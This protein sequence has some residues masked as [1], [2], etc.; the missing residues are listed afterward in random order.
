MLTTFRSI[1]F[2]AVSCF[3]FSAFGPVSQAAPITYSTSG[4]FYLNG[5]DAGNSLDWWNGASISFTGLNTTT[6]NEPTNISFGFFDT[7]GGWGTATIPTNTT[8]KLTVHQT[9]PTNNTYVDTATISGSLTYSDQS[10]VKVL[11]S[12]QD[13]TLG[14]VNYHLNEETSG[15]ALVAPNTNRGITTIQGSV[16][17]VPE[18]ASLLLIGAGLIGLRLS[19]KALLSR[20]KAR[21][22]TR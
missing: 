5:S 6:V 3:A 12:T 7:D 21:N 15:I 14:G 19:E 11:F 8:F 1:L 13:F 9:A 20:S 4:T 18:P 16:S 2:C 22:A 10:S 17:T